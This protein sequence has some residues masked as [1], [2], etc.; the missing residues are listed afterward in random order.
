MWR[1]RSH[2]QSVALTA[3]AVGVAFVVSACGA[4]L[5]SWR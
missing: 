3:F 5:R 2:H 4:L 1:K